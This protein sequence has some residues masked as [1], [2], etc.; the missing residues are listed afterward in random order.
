MRLRGGSGG[1]KLDLIISLA[2]VLGQAYAQ[3]GAD[4]KPGAAGQDGRQARACYA[5]NDGKGHREHQTFEQGRTV[6]FQQLLHP[7]IDYLLRC[8]QPV[9]PRHN[10][11]GKRRA[12]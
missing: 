4:H 8:A 6:L 2:A 10:P 3:K 12:Q 11:A 9:T 7:S 1:S 5:V